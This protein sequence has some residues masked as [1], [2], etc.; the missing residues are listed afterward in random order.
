MYPLAAI[1]LQL[2]KEEI[3]ARRVTSVVGPIDNGA[4]ANNANLAFCFWLAVFFEK[5]TVP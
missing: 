4:I 1:I 3:G 2:F 5:D